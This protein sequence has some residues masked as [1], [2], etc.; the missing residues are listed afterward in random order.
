MISATYG[1]E[2]NKLRLYVSERLDPETYER[3]KAVGFSW[4]PKQELFVAPKWT[5]EREDLLLDLA[6]EID[7]E[8][9]P[10][11]ERA[12]E[13]A[14][15]FDGYHD[16]RSTEADSAREYV[17]QI[18]GRFEFGQPILVGHHSEKRA[19]KDAERIENGLRKAVRLWDTASYWESRAERVVRHA[20]Y[21]ANP[22][23][24]ANR[25]KT[26]EAEKRS[27][28]RDIDKAQQRAESWRTIAD[29]EDAKVQLIAAIA[30]A[31]VS[32]SGDRWSKLTDG[33]LSPAQA[34]DSAI[35]S[36]A[37][38][39]AYAVRWIAH[40]NNRLAY[41][42]VLLGRA[43]DEETKVD[44]TRRG[45]AAL[46]LLNYK[47]ER[48]ETRNR[49]RQGTESTRQ[50]AMTAADFKKI[51][52]D[53]KG[54][55]VSADGTH[56]VRTA[57]VHTPGRGLSG[58]EHVVVFISDSKAHPVPVPVPKAPDPTAEEA[59][60][61]IAAEES[62]KEPETLVDEESIAPEAEPATIKQPNPFDA[63]R[64]SLKAGVQTVVVPE[65]FVTPAPLAQRVAE[66]A[67]IQPG[68]LVLEPSSG[69]AALAIAARDRGATVVCMDNAPAMAAAC[70]RAGFTT[71][72][73]DFLAQIPGGEWVFDK[74]VMNPVFSNEQDIQH[75]TH[76]IGF[77]KPGGRLVAITGP[78]WQFRQTKRARTFRALMDSLGA[79]VT[80][81][82]AGT[83]A[84]SGTQVRSL[85]ITIKLH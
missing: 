44:R 28:Q 68:D 24:R 66:E 62:A 18:A 76:A 49:W 47:A 21:K 67:D 72:E 10:L 83:F 74:V 51:Y 69:L 5:P 11:A 30:L 77:V 25:I 53:Y 63:M 52:D 35:A 71:V 78:G 15:R 56:R 60:A 45:S 7:D 80:E 27:H 61:E 81:L 36:C 4:A 40:L 33:T 59:E 2:D 48:I 55:R 64:A 13:R 38:V 75:V 70:R 46:P 19:R 84:T 50:V 6:G 16:K 8:D 31:N 14:E 58:G 37:R 79:K 54:T 1:P 82:P 23:V 65:L 29:C 32:L 3:V 22:R 85:L 26:L 42:R 12:A 34:A 9:T 17:Q 39:E 57:I 20:A 73:C 43:P 41:E